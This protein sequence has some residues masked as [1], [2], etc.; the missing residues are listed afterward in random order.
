[1]KQCESLGMTKHG[2]TNEPPGPDTVE[3]EKKKIRRWGKVK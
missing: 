1:M 2:S 3:K